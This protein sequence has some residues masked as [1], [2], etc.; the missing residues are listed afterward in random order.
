MK[1]FTSI[2][3][4][5][6]LVLFLG[7]AAHAGGCGSSHKADRTSAKAEAQSKDIIETAM[8]NESFSTLVAAV[9]AAGLVDILRGDGPFTVFAPTDEAFAQLPEGTLESLLADKAKLTAVLTYHVVSADV[10]AADVAKL[11]KAKTVNGQEVRIKTSDD[12]VMIDD[13]KVI[14]ADIECSN[15]TIHV[16]DSVILPEMDG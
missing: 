16:I 15:G 11:D 6:A 1:R 7:A 14:L 10:R 8:A 4:A 13:A 9:K 5:A 12:A 3:T 2:L